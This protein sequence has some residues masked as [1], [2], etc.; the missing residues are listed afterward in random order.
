MI[1]LKGQASGYRQ[2]FE[3]CD[4]EGDTYEEVT[5]KLGLS[6]RLMTMPP[7]I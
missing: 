4:C 1:F 3:A 5:E 2:I 6:V 7:N